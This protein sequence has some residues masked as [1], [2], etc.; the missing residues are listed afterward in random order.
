VT[1][2]GLKLQLTPA[3]SPEHA[4]LIAELNPYSGVTVRVT[5]LCPPALT[6]NEEGEAPSVKVGGGAEEIVSDTGVVSVTPP[7]VPTTVV[8]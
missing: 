4:K 3:G 2:V 6:F 8:V 1:V 7:L 5:V